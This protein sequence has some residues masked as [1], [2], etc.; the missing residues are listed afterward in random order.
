[1]YSSGRKGL[2]NNNSFHG[3]ESQIAQEDDIGP[4]KLARSNSYTSPTAYG[5]RHEDVFPQHDAFNEHYGSL[6]KTKLALG[7]SL[8]NL[9]ESCSMEAEQEDIH[10]LTDKTGFADKS[11]KD[12]SKEVP[13]EPGSGVGVEQLTTHMEHCRL[14]DHPSSRS[15]W[16]ESKP[17]ADLNDISMTSFSA[18]LDADD[19]D[20]SFQLTPQIMAATFH[21][22]DSESKALAME[23]VN[24]VLVRRGI[25][26][27]TVVSVQLK[28]KSL[29]KF[30]KYLSSNVVCYANQLIQWGIVI[31]GSLILFYFPERNIV[32]TV[33][34]DQHMCSGSRVIAPVV[35]YQLCKRNFLSTGIR[36]LTVILPSVTA[37]VF[38]K[39]IVGQCRDRLVYRYHRCISDES[40]EIHEVKG[41][42]VC[43]LK[44]NKTNE[45]FSKLGELEGHHR[46]Y[47]YDE[48]LSSRAL[49]TP[50]WVS[51][52]IDSDASLASASEKFLV[53]RDKRYLGHFLVS[54]AGTGVYAA[55]IFTAG[56]ME[57]MLLANSAHAI[58]PF[59]GSNNSVC[60]L[61]GNGTG[62]EMSGQ[63]TGFSPDYVPFAVA[64]ASTMGT[65]YIVPKVVSFSC[66]SLVGLVQKLYRFG[67]WVSHL[68][69]S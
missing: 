57:A 24:L 21:Q 67:R 9:Y 39:L 35:S 34:F 43:I 25:D 68:R 4:V 49:R 63:V 23:T 58:L 29:E 41:N 50:V 61:V 11:E 5:A 65:F 2:L 28:G 36:A 45:F 64:L 33:L 18:T 69:P 54:L 8:P 32:A 47:I 40:C 13:V 38:G 59:N 1:M 52:V 10:A 60:D 37:S 15:L 30:R 22:L 51:K 3:G 26:P 42:R 20:E 14:E 44:D 6:R 12:A 62:L 55:Y 56:Q 19:V 31:G 16:D 48:F 53:K 46:R 7:S 17:S 27:D 66:N